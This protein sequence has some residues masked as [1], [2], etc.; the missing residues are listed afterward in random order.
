LCERIAIINHGELVANDTTQN[1][2]RRLDNK[3]ITITLD[4]DIAAVPDALRAQGWELMPPRQ[5]TLF[6]KPS[7]SGIGALLAGVQAR[8]FAI[9]D[10]S[11]EETGG[12][13]VC[14]HQHGKH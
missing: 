9:A 3:R 4:H 8:G 7:Q 5:L 10:L 14:T 11:T 12:L 1:L 2:L 13:G 6:Y